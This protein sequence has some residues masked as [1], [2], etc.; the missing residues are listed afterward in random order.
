MR[1]DTIDIPMTKRKCFC[2]ICLGPG[3]FLTSLLSVIK[4]LKSH[5]GSTDSILIVT[6]KLNVEPF[7]TFEVIIL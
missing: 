4:I 2:R 1:R 6:I 3:L 5:R 7:D